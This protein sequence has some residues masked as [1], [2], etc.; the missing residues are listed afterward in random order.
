MNPNTTLIS[1]D[2][3]TPQMSLMWHQSVD[4]YSFHAFAHVAP[5][6]CLQDLKN[7]DLDKMT[8]SDY[9]A[10]GGPVSPPPVYR[11]H[12]LDLYQGPTSPSKKR[13]PSFGSQSSFTPLS[14]TGGF[15]SPSTGG[16]R[17]YLDPKVLVNKSSSELPQGVDPSRR[18]VGAESWGQVQKHET[19]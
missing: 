3:L 4:V 8:G 14:P 1:L 18:E 15:R 2:V 16:S 7:S 6:L 13:G 17:G 9:R 19:H 12:A 5:F 11:V 10:P